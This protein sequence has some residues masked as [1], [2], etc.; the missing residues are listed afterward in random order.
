MA[1]VL[2]DEVKEKIMESAIELFTE[3][4]F[5]N[6]TI[7]AIAKNAKV[8]VG[9]VYRYYENKE[10]LYFGVIQGVYEGVQGILTEVE[11]NQNY[12]LAFEKQ[13]GSDQLFM[14]MFNFVELYRREQKVFHMLLK[15]EKNLYYDKTILLFIEMLRDY[16]LKF[17]GKDKNPEGMSFVEASAFTNAIVFAVIDLL[18]HVEDSEL[19]QELMAFVTKM[20]KGFFYV[21]SNK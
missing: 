2:K 15:G 7:K 16:F 4:G 19:D 12:L 11:Q 21:K 20:I 8:S 17:W 14:P 5:Q 18:N 10:D 13:Q 1:Q 3:K 9:N 6:T